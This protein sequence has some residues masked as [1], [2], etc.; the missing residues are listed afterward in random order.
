MQHENWVYG[1]ECEKDARK[2]TEWTGGVAV[3]CEMNIR[4]VC[5]EGLGDTLRRPRKSLLV[6]LPEDC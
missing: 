4:C 6:S 1:Y 5:G 3:S 2:V